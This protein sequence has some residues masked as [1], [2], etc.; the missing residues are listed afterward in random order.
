MNH[1]K[2]R[3]GRRPAMSETP[4]VSIV[5][6]AY[7]AA[8][9][10]AETAR[11]VLAQTYE[12]WEWLVADDGSTDDTAKITAGFNDSR[13]RVLRREHV[14]LPAVGRNA[15]LA[16]AR[17]EYV[18]FLDADDAWLPDKLAA[19]VKYMKQHAEV[20]LVFTRYV[21]WYGGEATAAPVLPDTR[22]FPNPGNYFKLL[23]MGNPICIASVLVRRQLPAE[24]GGLDED[25]RLWGTADYEMW[26]RLAARVSFG[27]LDRPLVRYRVHP[28]GMSNDL[29]AMAKAAY[30]SV[31]KQFAAASV[32]ETDDS[33]RRRVRAEKLMLLGRAHVLEGDGG[34]ARRA[35]WESL[36]LRP[37]RRATWAWLFLSPWPAA[38]VRG[39]RRGV[40]ALKYR[41]RR[42]HEASA[43]CRAAEEEHV[44]M[45]T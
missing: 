22:G 38:V 31:E 28:G 14:G 10:I 24:C 9:F 34:K 1:R 3:R 21:Y 27:F 40:H 33:F 12:N 44:G 5:T 16:E 42:P 39:L 17:G 45:R 18:A 26:L 8:E 23:C 41:P 20:G 36:R 6:P 2:S 37:F 19:Q 43:A 13:I 32:A 25:P 30:L 4:L 7:N 35:L 29:S 15:A 11:S